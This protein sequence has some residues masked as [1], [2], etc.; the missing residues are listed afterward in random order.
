[1]NKIISVI[2][3][4]IFT[5]GASL[6]VENDK[7]ITDKFI[8]TDLCSNG[9]AL[10]Q[11]EGVVTGTSINYRSKNVVT[12]QTHDGCS[13]DFEVAQAF[14]NVK[15]NDTVTFEGRITN[16][17]GKILKIEQATRECKTLA[18]HHDSFTFYGGNEYT[19]NNGEL[20]TD[21]QQVRKFRKEMHKASTVFTDW[22]VCYTQSGKI[23]GMTYIGPTKNY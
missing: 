18:L 4:S 5:L 23:V 21:L 9:S 13:A 2:V 14:P 8:S 17:F 15:V 1:M 12:I 7:S 6:I 20:I 22:E 19:W 10:V 16:G 3:L 11:K